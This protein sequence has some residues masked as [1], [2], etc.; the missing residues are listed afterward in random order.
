M[1]FAKYPMDTDTKLHEQWD[2]ID[3]HLR[4]LMDLMLP[5][6]DADIEEFLSVNEFGLALWYLANMVNT[7]RTGEL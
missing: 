7:K 2:Q 1:L 4:R 5:E 6:A 3:N